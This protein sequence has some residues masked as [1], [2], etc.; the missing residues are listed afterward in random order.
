MI[1]GVSLL[2]ILLL[3]L[4]YPRPNVTVIHVLQYGTIHIVALAVP[5]TDNTL[6]V[7]HMA[8]N[9]ALTNL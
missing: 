7:P 5:M 1:C 3:L 6:P 4:P 9:T 2:L 8:D